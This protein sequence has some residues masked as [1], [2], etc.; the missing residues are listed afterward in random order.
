MYK[1]I[2]MKKCQIVTDLSHGRPRVQANIY[3][4][5]NIQNT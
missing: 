4:I 1:K 2:R 3:K 5:Q